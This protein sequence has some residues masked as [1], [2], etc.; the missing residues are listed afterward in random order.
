MIIEIPLNER[1]RA[2]LPHVIGY[3]SLPYLLTFNELRRQRKMKYTRSQGLFLLEPKKK[4][5]SNLAMSQEQLT[6]KFR[7]FWECYP[8]S[9]WC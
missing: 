4:E 7:E 2:I 1:Q 5:L 9:Y 3:K 6:M 8:D